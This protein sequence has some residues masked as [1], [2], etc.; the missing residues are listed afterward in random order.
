M[1]EI[2]RTD[3]QVL[4]TLDDI[5][6][7]CWIN[8]VDPTNK[9]IEQIAKRFKNYD[10]HLVFESMNEEFDGTYNNPNPEYYNNINAYNQIFVDTVRKAGGKNNNRYLLV[11]GWNTDINYTAGDYG[12]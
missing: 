8:M 10:D 1:V 11:P 12:F 5:Q 9:E 4:S 2:Y 7:G 6:E 3:Q